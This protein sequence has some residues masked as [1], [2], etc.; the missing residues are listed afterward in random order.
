MFNIIVFLS[1]SSHD[2][3][4]TEDTSN[5]LKHLGFYQNVKASLHENLY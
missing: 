5:P 4:L 2:F 1:M 3:L